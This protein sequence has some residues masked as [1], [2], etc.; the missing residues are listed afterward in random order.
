MSYKLTKEK[1]LSDFEQNRLTEI[2]EKFE[3][4]YQR[5]T[6]LIWLALFSGGRAKELL[7]ITVKDLDKELQSVFIRGLKGSDD[8]EIP[9][10]EWLFKKLI[11]L[12]PSEDG[13]IF[14]ISYQRL[15]QIWGEFRPVRKKFHSLRHSFAINVYRKT[16]DLRILQVALGHKNLKNTMIYAQYQYRTDELRKA[17]V[18]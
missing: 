8:R 14:P 13:R 16:K 10:P 2:L 12:T 5:D 6:A 11:N 1:Y 4:K 3:N 18:G 7:N 15:D 17:L 9:V